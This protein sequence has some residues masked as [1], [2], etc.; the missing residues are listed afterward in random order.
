MAALSR[1]DPGA[2]GIELNRRTIGH[3]TVV[4]GVSGMSGDAHALAMSMPEDPENDVVVVD[5]APDLPIATW[6]QVAKQVPKHRR[7]VR[8]V[9]RGHSREAAALAGLW[10]SERLRRPVIAPDGAIIPGLGG[11]LF[12]HSGP[13]SGWVRFHNNRP[14]RWESKRFPR[15]TWESAITNELT[16]TSAHGVA[17]PLPGGVWIRP[18]SYAR[19]EKSHRARLVHTVP[20]QWDVLTV[21]LGC[22][23]T[24]ALSLDDVARVLHQVPAD[25][26]PRMRF[27]GYGPMAV[28]VGRT[29]GQ[30]LADLVGHAVAC[31]SGLPTGDPADPDVFTVQPDGQR[32]WRGFVREVGYRPTQDGRTLTPELISHR[33]PLSGLSQVAPATYWYAPDAVIEVVQSGLLMRAPM[34]TTRTTALRAVPADA[35]SGSL[36]FDGASDQVM[37]RMGGLAED[38][39]GRLDPA[40][41]R[42]LRLLPASAVLTARSPAVPGT[43]ASTS[44]GPVLDRFVP[45]PALLASQPTTRVSPRA[46]AATA[47]GA[48]VRTEVAVSAP[49][50]SLPAAVALPPPQQPVSAHPGV[51]VDVPA[52]T[53]SFTLPPHTPTSPAA[54]SSGGPPPGAATVAPPV[55]VV[56]PA[57]PVALEPQPPVVARAPQDAAEAPG[58]PAG[59]AT[60]VRPQP[61]PSPDAAALVPSGGLDKERDWLRKTLGNDFGNRSNAVARVLSE[62]PGFQGALSRS[63]A[64]VLADAVAVQL[65]LSAEGAAV[66]EALGQGGNGAHVPLA[67]C[68]VG[69]LSR[70]PSHRGPSV[71]PVTLSPAHA[72]YYRDR[73]IVTDWRFLHALTEPAADLP[74]D[75]DVVIWA[76]TARRTKLLEPSGGQLEDRVLFVPGTN[77]KVLELVEPS[78]DARGRVLLRE[79]AANE[80]DEHGRIDPGRSSLDKLASNSLE[81]ALEKWAGAPPER[82]IGSAATRFGALP[83]LLP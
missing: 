61:V 66:D 60:D 14:P 50:A 65:Y 41:A 9:L 34:E 72:A 38:L 29:L 10:L 25:V 27:V 1:L 56:A 17:E 49:V 5:M 22:P 45:P 58:P 74:G 24:P 42:H 35:A 6:E 3:A 67:R 43:P 82:R 52:P 70:L 4:H 62:H 39:R 69:G 20:M 47:G 63:S 31:Y 36:I 81:H 59:R 57:P 15:P 12:V 23:G 21:V 30:A 77:F 8:L 80:I 83:G 51:A 11:A 13:G 76:M 73:P 48:S 64:E 33:P 19:Q 28:P 46:G 68:V 18:V 26:T 71:Y 53:V 79:L 44:G 2:D 32:G 55:E 7:G 37:A 78:A 40:I 75:T 54:T 16:S